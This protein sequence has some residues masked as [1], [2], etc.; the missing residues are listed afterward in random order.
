MTP[1][2]RLLAEDIPTRPPAPPKPSTEPWTPEEQ[3]QHLADL[4]AALNGWHW[5][6]DTSLS[7]KRRHLRL[8]RRG[9]AA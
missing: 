8:L 5:E 3:A 4:N 1:Y 7:T 6:G 9:Q 2:E